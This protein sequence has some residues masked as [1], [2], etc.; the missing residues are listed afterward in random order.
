MAT[1]LLAPSGAGAADR[2]RGPDDAH[3]HDGSPHHAAGGRARRCRS[4][5]GA[6][7]SPRHGSCARRRRGRVPGGRRACT[8]VRCGDVRRLHRARRHRHVPR[9]RRSRPRRGAQPGRPRAQLLRSRAGRVCGTWLSD[10]LD[11]PAGDRAP[12]HGTGSCVA[13]PAVP[14]AAR[15]DARARAVRPARAACPFTARPCRDGRARR[16]AGSAVRLRPV[17]R[18]Q[19]ARRRGAPA[20]DRGPRGAPGTGAQDD[21]GGSGRSRAPQR[22]QRRCDGAGGGRAG[23]RALALA[24]GRG[25]RRDHDC[26]RAAGAHRRCGAARGERPA[27]AHCRHGARQPCASI[28]LRPGPRRMARRRLP[29]GSEPA[30]AR[31]APSACGRCDRARRRR[32]GGAPACVGRARLRG[33][34]VPGRLRT[35][36]IRLTVGRRQGTGHRLARAAVRL[37][38]RLRVAVRAAPGS[39]GRAR[40]GDRRR[41]PVVE[42]CSRIARRPWR[43]ATAS[44]SSSTS[45]SASA[46]RA[47]P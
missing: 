47:L 2:G 12:A 35:G 40:R 14:R 37:A 43:R 24:A 33:I 8:A 41:C 13:L 22:A 30:L 5:D 20:A 10:R 26:A 25:A 39:G 38:P 16:P 15:G 1:A 31:C 28:A 21:P 7:A 46:A 11:A 44:P 32:M 42:R 6:S 36:G 29:Q 27:G 4:R 45:A 23:A 19:G 34:R 18:D 17:G 3:E 9:D